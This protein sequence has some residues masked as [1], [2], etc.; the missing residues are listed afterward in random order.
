MTQFCWCRGGTDPPKNDKI[1]RKLK[2]TGIFRC[3]FMFK[4]RGKFWFLPKSSF[5]PPYMGSEDF[6]HFRSFWWFGG[7]GRKFNVWS[8]LLYFGFCESIILFNSPR[9][10]P[11]TSS[12]PQT[13]PDTLRTPY[14]HPIDTL[15]TPSRLESFTFFLGS[16]GST[17]GQNGTYT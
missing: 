10:P 8:Y 16:Q 14:R 17:L 5:D 13:P 4:T 2:L 11:D 1:F 12:H 3:S 15:Q 7:T 9:H 6:A